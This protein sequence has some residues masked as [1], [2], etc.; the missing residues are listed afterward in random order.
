[1]TETTPDGAAFSF[2]MP[3]AEGTWTSGTKTVVASS[4]GGAVTQNISFEVQDPAVCAIAPPGSVNATQ[5][6]GE[7][8]VPVTFSVSVSSNA[9]C[10]APRLTLPTE[11]GYATDQAMTLQSGSTYTF[12]MP[13]GQGAGWTSKTYTVPVSV[14]AGATAAIGLVVSNAPVCSLSNLSVSPS[15]AS[16]K[17]NGQKEIL[18]QVTITVARNS[19]SVCAVP[20]VTVTPGASGEGTADLTSPQE[21]WN[22][23]TTATC[24][25][26]VCEYRILKDARGWAPTVPSTRTVTVTASGSTLTSTLNLVSG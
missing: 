10:G 15:S 5:V 21:M 17:P 18:A 1:M 12:T 2:T 19:T 25:G 8:T 9:V 14:N 11:A 24:T 23:T 7:L 13:A 26:L 22:P 4:K 16:V 20:T 6:A 3:A